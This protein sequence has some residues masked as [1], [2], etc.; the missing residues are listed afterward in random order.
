MNFNQFQKTVESNY[1][2]V[3]P[4]GHIVLFVWTGERTKKIILR[5]FADRN[6]TD[7]LMQVYGYIDVP[8]SWKVS[9]DIPPKSVVEYGYSYFNSTNLIHGKKNF[10]LDRASGDFSGIS[11][12]LASN[13]R[14][15]RR[16]LEKSHALKH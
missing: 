7:D 8:F 10:E 4:N 12:K 13:F 5:P 1:K 2:K 16:Q 6:S 9:E 3:F 15:M 14:S 11:S